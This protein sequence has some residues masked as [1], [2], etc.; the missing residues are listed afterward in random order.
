MTRAEMRLTWLMRA[1]AALFAVAAFCYLFL[2]NTAL[3]IA[4]AVSRAVSDLPPIPLST[5][6]FWVVLGFS[7]LVT[8]TLLAY[9]AQ[10]DIR[11]NRGY[12]SPILICKL[13]STVAYLA[14]FAIDRHLAYFLGA[15]TDGTL[16]AL[17]YV[18]YR[19]IETADRV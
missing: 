7:M 3:R 4:N 15:A 14:L 11:A 5:E 18:F 8:L 13:S 10:R 9:L 19:A 16:L 2:P 1:Y 6:R 17:G 12:I